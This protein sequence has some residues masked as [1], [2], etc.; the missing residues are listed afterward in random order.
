MPSVVHLSSRFK[1]RISF[2]SPG[3][4]PTMPRNLIEYHD[5]ILSN[6]S[7]KSFSRPRK[8]KSSP[9]TTNLT[10]LEGLKYTDGEPLPFLKPASINFRE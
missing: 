7:N 1:M 4:G 2:K 6:M 3:S 10:P 9:Q 8:V 5:L